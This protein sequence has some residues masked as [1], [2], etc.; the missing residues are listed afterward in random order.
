MHVAFVLLPSVQVPDPAAVAAAHAELFPDAPPFTADDAEGEPGAVGLASD[1][2]IAHLVLTAGPVP[3]GEAERA[4][5]RS[6]AAVGQDPAI[7][8]YAA[9]LVVVWNP[10]FELTLV[11]GL[12]AQSR[13][14]AAIVQVSGAAGVYVAAA[15]T[16]HPPDWYVEVARVIDEPIMLWTGVSHVFG[17]DER[18]SFLSY[19]MHQFGLPDVLLTAPADA[20]SDAIEYLFELLLRG[21]V[22]GQLMADGQTVGPEPG[23]TLPAFIQPNP[24]DPET[25]V[26][27]VDL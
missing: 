4:A 5:A 11:E 7:P 1:A 14:I 17:D 13:L 26:M 18:H 9:H 25:D 23:T 16:T 3:G 2:G 15:S 6:L 20:G 21:A 22:A 24:V 27:C 8:V 12:T 19:G 10:A